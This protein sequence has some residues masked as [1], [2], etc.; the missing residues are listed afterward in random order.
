MVASVYLDCRPILTNSTMKP[1]IFYSIRIFLLLLGLQTGMHGK[2]NKNVLL[3]ISDDLMKQVEVYGHDETKTPHLSTFADEALLFDRAYCQFPLCGPSRASMMLSKYP[4]NSGITWNQA[5]KSANT[6]RVGR[7][8]G[9]STLPAFFKHH[10]YITV[11]GGKL[12]HNSVIPDDADT[13][14]DFTV[15]L[16]NSGHDGIKK[17]I[18]DPNTGKKVKRSA[19]TESSKRGIYDHKDG[20]LVG[21]AKE[22]L[23]THAES[24]NDQ[25]FFMA[26]GIK[27]PHSPYSCPEQFW[28][29]YDRA[30]LKLPNAPAP[31]D[32]NTHYSLT[33]PNAQLLTAFDTEQ[34]TGDTLPEEKAR[35]LVHGYY[36]CV[37][38]ADH[39]AGDLIQSLK[40]NELYDDTIVIFT[41]DH[42]YKLGE[43]ARWGKFT[44]HEKDAVVP[45][46]VRSPDHPQSHGQNTEAI[47]GLVDLYPTLAELSNLPSPEN[48]DGQSFAKTFADPAYSA[49]QYIR[50]VRPQ[51]K[52]ASGV[53]VIHENGFRYKHFYAGKLSE[54]PAD[55]DAFIAF[56][57]YDH[58]H[59]NNTAIST[60][61]LYKEQ[62]ELVKQMQMLALEQ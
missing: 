57:L 30:A 50:T 18:K 59:Q 52:D 47:V 15:A 31:S 43:Y 27:K 56:E 51:G 20:N 60:E 9:V 55:N 35:E 39:L 24:E 14:A 10:G 21:K 53:T 58:Y 36:A 48:I 45:L 42:G 37:S 61:N 54:P 11:G 7:K 19:M 46:L 62:P 32:I 33:S 22:W 8:L 26:I 16:F 44:L 25:P 12:Y 2:S 13:K 28:D 29:I 4:E 3:I 38:Y 6:Q 1:L 40:D 34:Y 23:K 5:G 49:R 41:S 17:Q